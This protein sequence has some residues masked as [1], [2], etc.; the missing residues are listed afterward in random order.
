MS[1]IITILC[2][3]FLYVRLTQEIKT[4]EKKQEKN[5]TVGTKRSSLGKVDDNNDLIVLRLIG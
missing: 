5:E 1:W 4:K 2:A 3:I